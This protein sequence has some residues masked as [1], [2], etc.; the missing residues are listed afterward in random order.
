MQ[1]VARDG[2]VVEEAG[3]HPR[4]FG[5]LMSIHC[6]LKKKIC[7]QDFINSLFRMFK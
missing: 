1:D 5:H 4:S 3:L 6:M 2:K 7:L